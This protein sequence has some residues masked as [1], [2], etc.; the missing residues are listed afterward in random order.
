[1]RGTARSEG[2]K[3]ELQSARSFYFVFETASVLNLSFSPGSLVGKL[4]VHLSV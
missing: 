2:R 3:T 4:V 1:M